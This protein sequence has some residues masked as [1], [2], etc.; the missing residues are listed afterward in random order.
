MII[1][2]VFFENE[3]TNFWNYVKVILENLLHHAWP[4]QCFKEVTTKFSQGMYKVLIITIKIKGSRLRFPSSLQPSQMGLTGD[5][6]EDGVGNV[7]KNF[8]LKGNGGGCV[9]LIEVFMKKLINLIGH[10]FDWVI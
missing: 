7:T 3:A 4:G 1:F 2:V 9:Y 5:N 6:V 10:L 8:S